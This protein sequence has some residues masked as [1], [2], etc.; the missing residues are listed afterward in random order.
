MPH[1]QQYSW[2]LT[3]IKNVEDNVI[4]P[5]WEVLHFDYFAAYLAAALQSILPSSKHNTLSSPVVNAY[6]ITVSRTRIYPSTT[7]ILLTINVNHWAR[8]H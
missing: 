5:T 6:S 3:L 7:Q 2:N 4:V 1:L 8:S